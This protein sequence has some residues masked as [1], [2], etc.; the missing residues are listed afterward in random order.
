MSWTCRCIECV[1]DQPDP[2]YLRGALGRALASGD[3]VRMRV[4]LF[5]L[6]GLM[7]EW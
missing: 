6:G 5:S 4:A 7:G 1:G 3:A 2:V